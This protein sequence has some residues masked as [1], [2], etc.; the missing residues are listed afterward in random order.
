[1]SGIGSFI[2]S[3]FTPTHADSEE[4][5]EAAAPAEEAKEEAE[6]EEEEP[7]D[8]HPAI[9]EACM[10]RP[11]CAPAKHHFEK[12]Q[13]KVQAGEGFKGEDCVEEMCKSPV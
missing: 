7:E 3:L 4:K 1:M 9:R 8:A 6:E 2:T 5:P 11:E 10:S 12:C 13:E